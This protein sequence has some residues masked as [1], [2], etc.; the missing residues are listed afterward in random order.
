MRLINVNTL[1]LKWFTKGALDFPP[2]I[3]ASHTWEDDEVTYED[4]SSWLKA[5]AA[6]S[7]VPEPDKAGFRKL[8][9]FCR[10]VR[11]EFYI[12]PVDFEVR[13]QTIRTERRAFLKTQEAVA[14]YQEIVGTIQAIDAGH[15]FKRYTVRARE[16]ERVEWAWLDTCCIDKRSSAE[17]SEAINSMFKWYEDAVT[18]VAYLQDFG[19]SR[20]RDGRLL[21]TSR[22][23]TR[24]WTLQELIAPWDVH[25]YNGFW[26]Y[27]YSRSTAFSEISRLTSIDWQILH[28][29]GEKARDLAAR[30]KRMLPTTRKSALKSQPIALKLSWAAGRRT[31]RT[32]DSA[33]SLL[34]ILNINM[35]LLYG[36]GENAFT[37]L[38]ETVMQN[39]QDQSILL[40]QGGSSPGSRSYG[41]PLGCLAKRP[42]QFTPCSFGRMRTVMNPKIE[43]EW[44][45]DKIEILT[46]SADCPDST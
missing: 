23:F 34:G 22:W 30:E 38:Q 21:R 20:G 18:C 36:E 31:T 27:C 4:H 43:R 17:L 13:G 26:T 29:Y 6:S 37:R 3:I 14:G 10:T 2:Y 25:F 8:K 1:E 33:Y 15:L 40:W 7:Q 24:G 41:R 35:P 28:T 12:L 39:S 5:R 11:E 19:R 44:P 9:E 42:S 45:L 32:E 16:Q 46:F